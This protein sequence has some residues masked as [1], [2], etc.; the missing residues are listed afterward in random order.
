MQ[1]LKHDESMK[2]GVLRVLF[3]KLFSL[4]PR[5]ALK[6]SML[7]SMDSVLGSFFW[8][9]LE[10]PVVQPQRMRE[11]RARIDN[12]SHRLQTNIMPMGMDGIARNR[13]KFRRGI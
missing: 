5:V 7:F 6:F 4:I 12:R 9:I 3:L 2:A 10:R 8:Y 11:T 1:E 13:G